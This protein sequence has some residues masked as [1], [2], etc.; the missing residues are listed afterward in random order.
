[1]NG[2]PRRPDIAHDLVERAQA[3]RRFREHL[4]RGRLSA[5]EQQ[6]GAHQERA[7]SGVLRRVMGQH[8]WPGRS[9]V[10]EEGAEAAWWLALHADHEPP[11]QRLALRMLTDA[12]ERGEATIQQ[13]A[14]LHDRCQVVAAPQ[15]YG[16]QYRQD[17]DGQVVRLP[18][19][20][21]ENLDARRATVG[22]PPAAVAHDSLRRRYA[23]GP[24]DGTDADPP[25]IADPVAPAVLVGSSA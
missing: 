1:M 25:D 20:T 10:G 15:L 16:T 24:H 17:P 19:E 18:V 22:L 8:G 14:H 6:W 5:E 23:T 13:W 3:A 2:E 7:N 9:L 21:P 4:T 11:F 12:V